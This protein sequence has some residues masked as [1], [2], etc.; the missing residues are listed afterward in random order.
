MKK[1]KRTDWNGNERRRQSCAKMGIDP[2]V[3][4]GFAM[5]RINDGNIEVIRQ[6]LKELDRQIEM[7]LAVYSGMEYIAGKTE[8]D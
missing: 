5:F 7:E 2:S 3:A 8:K 4:D 6:E 1:Q